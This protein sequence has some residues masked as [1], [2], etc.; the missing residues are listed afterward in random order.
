MSKLLKIVTVLL[1]IVYGVQLFLPSQPLVLSDNPEL[2]VPNYVKLS[3][4]TIA[5]KQNQLW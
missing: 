1:K 3:L 4:S 5:Q 2:P